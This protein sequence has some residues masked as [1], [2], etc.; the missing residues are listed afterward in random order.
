[1]RSEKRLDGLTVFTR[2]FHTH[3]TK[4]F[5]G[6]TLRVRDLPFNRGPRGKRSTHG[7]K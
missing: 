3:A 2:Y 7:G 6:I 5:D 1:M 4:N